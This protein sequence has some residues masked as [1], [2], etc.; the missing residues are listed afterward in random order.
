MKPIQKALTNLEM[1]EQV[2]DVEEYEEQVVVGLF[3]V[4]AA[5]EEG[6]MLTRFGDARV[7]FV[8]D[9]TAKYNEGE[10]EVYEDWVHV[11][12][13]EQWIPRDRVRNVEPN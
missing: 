7:R 13:D 6:T 1:L 3:N 11:V 10:I 4:A 8:D 2:E 12:D 9:G 5:L